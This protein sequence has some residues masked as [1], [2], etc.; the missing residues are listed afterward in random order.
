MV[1]VLGSH[2]AVPLTAAVRHIPGIVFAVTTVQLGIPHYIIVDQ[3]RNPAAVSCHHV[4]CIAVVVR[5]HIFMPHHTQMII[6]AYH[7]V[8]LQSDPADFIGGVPAFPVSSAE[9]E[10]IPAVF[11][12]Q[13]CQDISGFLPCDFP[14]FQILSIKSDQHLVQP[15]ISVAMAVY[16]LYNL[17]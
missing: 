15:S 6:A 5:I 9:G 12:V 2:R 10:I 7:I 3:S 11:Q 13:F 8:G 17:E 16:P 14:F 4:T 1:A